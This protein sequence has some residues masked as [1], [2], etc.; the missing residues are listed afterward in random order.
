MK[1]ED[2]VYKR[3]NM[4]TL[5][6]DFTEALN[7]FNEA[8]SVETK[9]KAIDTINALRLNFNTM[10][11]LA[12]IRHT[13]DTNDSYYDEEKQFFNE[14]SPLFTQLNNM[15]YKALTNTSYREELEARKGA[16]LFKEAEL[17]LKTFHPDIIPDL[18]EENR[19]ANDFQ[20][21]LASAEIDFEGETRNLSQMG[22]FAQS[23]DR[24]MRKKASR[25]TTNYLK[26]NE[27][28]LDDIYDKLIKVRTK[29]ASTLGYENFVQ[30]AYD[31]WGR[32]D[33]GPKEVANYRDQV[34]QTIVPL[35][36]ELTKRKQ[37]RLK[38]DTIYHYDLSLDFE[39]GNPAPKGKKD[40]LVNHASTM[41]KEMSPETDEFF[42]FMRERNLLD[43]EAKKGKAGG[44]YCTFLPD[45]DSPFIFSN[46]NGTKGD[47]DVLTHEAG[48]AFQMY[49]SR[50]HEVPE[51]L[52]A[53]Q[54]IMEIHSMSM[55]FFAW[56]W[57]NLF[58]EEDTEKYKF[59][60]LS[61]ALM[62]I[63]YG[64]LIDE[65]QHRVYEEPTLSIQDRK[66]VWRDLEKKY[67][68]YKVYDDND[69][70]ERGNSWQTIMHLYVVPFYMID[71]TLA[72][73][74]AF[75]YWIRSKHDKKEAWDSYVTL[76]KAGGSD[77]FLGLLDLAN[78]KNPFKDG[79]LNKVIPDIKAYTDSVDDQAL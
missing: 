17:S 78:L 57:V 1:F 74:C 29:I 54:D 60:H 13:I 10:A 36:E 64:V 23:K 22:P 35:N 73:V 52:S 43:L 3:P 39:S 66:N 58:F 41:Y 67:F 21:L 59:S 15:F 34:H 12:N 20:K 45:Y 40:W 48:H 42:T 46:F 14:N 71:Y 68:P 27:K 65:F 62:L 32:M 51:Y 38:L 69:Y 26:E 77:T 70:L 53:T 44:G 7:R 63:A 49:M 8:D 30:L 37:K 16:L 33:Y 18:Q 6:K 5:K 28:T 9:E 56:P 61:Q 76:C 31:R 50:H 72:Q 4:E 24:E 11:T 25:A 75:Q 55:E 2:Y 19:L 47:V 79:T